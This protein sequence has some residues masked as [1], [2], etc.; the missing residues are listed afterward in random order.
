MEAA[1]LGKNLF[2]AA[3]KDNKHFPEPGSIISKEAI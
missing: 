2:Q 3:M 1:T